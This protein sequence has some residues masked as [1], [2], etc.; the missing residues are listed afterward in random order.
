[1]EYEIPIGGGEGK[2][3]LQL[4]AEASESEPQESEKLRKSE[5]L[6][7]A[8]SASATGGTVNTVLKSS[9]SKLTKEAKCELAV[10]A[11][12]RAFSQCPNLSLLVGACLVLSRLLVEPCLSC[13]RI[14]IAAA[15]TRLHHAD[16]RMHP[17]MDLLLVPL[18]S[19]RISPLS[20]SLR[21]LPH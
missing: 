8:V 6:E 7:R 13:L 3:L 9:S 14:C 4:I 20:L 2:G 10:I 11:V 15:W 16:S 18:I 17:A 19:P 1:L 12:K 5:L 21:F